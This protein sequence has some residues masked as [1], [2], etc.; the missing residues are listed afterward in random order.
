[1]LVA[2]LAEEI[3]LAVRPV[4]LVQ[5]DVVGAQAPQAVVQ[6]LLDVGRSRRFLPPRTCGSQSPGPATLL[7]MI[8]RSRP[9]RREPAADV[10]LGAAHGLALGRHR[11][12]LGGVDE[13]DAGGDGAVELLGGVASVF[14]SPKVMVPRQSALTRSSVRPSGRVAHAESS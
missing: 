12:H 10:L 1:V 8:R 5:V 13:I 11:I 4:Q 3:G 9:P 14:C 6:G 7:A 2:E